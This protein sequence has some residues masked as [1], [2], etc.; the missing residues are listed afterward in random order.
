MYPERV[1]GIFVKEILQ[2]QYDED[3]REALLAVYNLIPRLFRMCEPVSLFGLQ[4]ICL[5]Y[6]YWLEAIEI[7]V[8][9]SVEILGQVFQQLAHL[10]FA[11]TVTALIGRDEVVFPAESFRPGRSAYD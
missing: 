4:V 1:V 11:P 10:A 3:G 7:A 5:L 6:H 9:F 2:G 8:V